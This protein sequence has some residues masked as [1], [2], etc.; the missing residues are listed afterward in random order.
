[1]FYHLAYVFERNSEGRL[2]MEHFLAKESQCEGT[3][4]ALFRFTA[5]EQLKLVLPERAKEYGFLRAL[6]LAEIFREQM[7]EFLQE[8]AEVWGGKVPRVTI[9]ESVKLE[10][11]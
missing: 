4:N 7:L 6:N 5:L 2:E 8:N 9:E 3:K 10:K 11:L 1:M